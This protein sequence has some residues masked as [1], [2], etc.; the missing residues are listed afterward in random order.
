MPTKRKRSRLCL[1]RVY[2]GNVLGYTLECLSRQV[3]SDTLSGLR[4][5]RDDLT[6]MFVRLENVLDG[7]MLDEP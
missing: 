1:S 6:L 7:A 5:R 4:E 3:E 2:W